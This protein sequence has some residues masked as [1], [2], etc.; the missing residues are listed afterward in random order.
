[1]NALT[2][3]GVRAENR[4]FATL[5]PTTRRVHVNDVPLLLTD[6]VGFVQKL[7][8]NLVAAFRATL[9]EVVEADLLIHVVDARH[10]MAR[11]Q[12]A[13]VVR[14]LRELGAANRPTVTVLNKV[15]RVE[16]GMPL[17]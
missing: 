17:P 2:G 8:A 12:A 1:M 13:E 9:E 6:T 16:D 11:E 3:A 7:P 14:V 4:L 15:D 5:D 10:P